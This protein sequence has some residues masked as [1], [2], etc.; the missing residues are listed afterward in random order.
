MIYPLNHEDVPHWITPVEK[1]VITPQSTTSYDKRGEIL[2]NIET[3][4][5]IL[6][7]TNKTE[8]FITRILNSEN[9]FSPIYLAEVVARD[10]PDFD[11]LENTANTIELNSENNQIIADAEL[12]SIVVTTYENDQ[13]ISIREKRFRVA[14]RGVN[15]PSL[16]VVTFYEKLKD[17]IDVKRIRKKLIKNYRNSVMSSN[18]EERSEEV[19]QSNKPK[20]VPNPIEDQATLLLPTQF[21]KKTTVTI[22][23]VAGKM[24]YNNQTNSSQTHLL[25][26]ENLP[27]GVYTLLLQN[28][29][30]TDSIK[31]IK[32]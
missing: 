15:V 26:V 21:Q 16:D 7:S 2:S 3:G 12:N 19:T 17:K 18:I 14:E 29:Q 9:E 27:N 28:D 6:E 4:E 5:T 8:K 11:V 22:L 13:L 1:V 23:D 30:Q 32:Q 10:F 25:R 31:F 24:V 20:I